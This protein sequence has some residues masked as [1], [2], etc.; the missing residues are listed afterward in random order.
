M[1]S[2]LDPTEDL[3]EERIHELEDKYEDITNN[4]TQTKTS[5][6]WIRLTDMK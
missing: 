2:R 5:K 6:L 1:N 3:V 4:S